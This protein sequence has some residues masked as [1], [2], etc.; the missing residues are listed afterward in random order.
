M[1]QMLSIQP[2]APQAPQV[3]SPA[4]KNQSRFSPHLDNAISGK[5]QHH[6]ASQ[7]DKSSKSNSSSPDKSSS[8]DSNNNTSE[9]QD[10]HNSKDTANLTE[11]GVKEDVPPMENGEHTN[12]TPPSFETKG[13]SITA[14]AFSKLQQVESPTSVFQTAT[15]DIGSKTITSG[16]TPGMHGNQSDPQA[17]L[18]DPA[19]P[20]S[21][22]PVTAGRQ[23]AL[24]NQLQQIINNAN[25]TGTVSITRVGNLSQPASADSN[26]HGVATANFSGNSDISSLNFN[27]LLVADV[28]GIEKSSGKAGQHLNGIRHDNQH[29]YYNAKINTVNIAENNQNFQGN[30]SS[31][32]FSQ[33]NMTSTFQN[34]PIGAAEP[35]NTF[36][37][38]SGLVQETTQP[39]SDSAK[40]VILPSGTVVYEEEVIQQMTERL[41]MS[42]RQADSR[43]NLKLHPVE[44]GQLKID[45]TVKDGAIRANVVAQSQHTLEILEKNI[46]KLK[47]VLENQGFTIDQISF[48]AESD[49]VGEFDLFDQ[50]LFSHNDYTPTP[51]KDRFSDESDFV[52]EDSYLGVPEMSTGV[53][54]KI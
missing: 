28:D 33:Q 26:I 40:P 49:S 44:L 43:I 41:R 27:E 51:N 9:P 15:P 32:E 38:I 48:S 53:N 19:V 22:Q 29:Q 4:K 24:I 54:V 34:G 11:G 1:P 14:P 3:G 36:S 39:Q 35:T 8:T 50:Q 21:G 46:S 47:T 7:K 20:L 42:S 6:Q 16:N 2:A 13:P 25:E 30:R 45:L 10:L 37:Q 5:K 31:D 52:L 12:L 18:S 23:D 17:V